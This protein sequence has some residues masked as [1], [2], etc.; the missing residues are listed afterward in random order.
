MKPGDKPG[1]S[2]I[3]VSGIYPGPG[4]DKPVGLKPGGEPGFSYIPF[5]GIH[6]GPRRDKPGMQAARL[7]FIAFFFHSHHVFF[8]FFKVVFFQIDDPAGLVLSYNQTAAVDRD[9]LFR[10]HKNRAVILSVS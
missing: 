7:L 8:R 6:P 1:V 3:P 10:N 9:I 5:P 2:C 4:R